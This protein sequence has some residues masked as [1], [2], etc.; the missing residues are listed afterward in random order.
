MNFRD[1]AL[2]GLGLALA[3]AGERASGLRAGVVPI[4]C[5]RTPAF[6][7]RLIAG[8]AKKY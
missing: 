7:L 2:V 1:R 6:A 4:N 8:S 5:Q 3:G